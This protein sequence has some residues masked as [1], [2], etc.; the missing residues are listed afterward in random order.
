MRSKRSENTRVGAWLWP[1]LA[2][3]GVIL[4]ACA[5]GQ[6]L[7]A[8]HIAAQVQQAEAQIEDYHAVV[9]TVLIE[10]GSGDGALTQEIW[11]KGPNLLRTEVR[12]GPA[13]M[14]GQVAVSDGEQVWL[15]DPLLKQAQVLPLEGFLHLPRA[16][17]GAMVSAI[18]EQ[19]LEQSTVDYIGEEIVAG[20]RAYRIEL[21]PWSGTGLFAALGEGPV[22]VW[23]DQQHARRLKIE[24]PLP[25]DAH[26][27]MEY[28]TI[29]YN[30][31]LA[32][33]LFQFTPPPGTSMS[34][35][36]TA[37][38]PPSVQQMELDAAQ[39]AA[40][41]PLLLPAHAPTG[42]SFAQARV[43][44]GGGSVTLIYAGHGGSLSITE[45]LQT[46]AQRPSTGEEVDVQGTR[47]YLRRQGDCFLSLS[48]ETRELTIFVTGTVSPEEALR[49]AR[50]ME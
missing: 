47:A 28:R 16:Q 17:L 41:F 43:V 11:R 46:E 31:G 5:P 2:I 42:M 38:R 37:D 48:W 14:I 9:K 15:Y 1:V 6:E 19:L 27:T 39:D 30:T 23:I 13:E 40:G 34:V 22:A 7:T 36:E 33:S 20:R 10:P 8:D 49:V 29:E 26:Y 24:I 12:E 25:G 35:G 21:T 4:L 44:E 18:A 50:S 32:D 3:I 45:A